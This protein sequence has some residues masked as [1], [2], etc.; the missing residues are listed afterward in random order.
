MV[1]KSWAKITEAPDFSTAS[2]LQQFRASNNQLSDISCL[3]G[4]ASINYIDV[5][6]NAEIK[7]IECLGACPMIVQINA[8]GTK[9]TKAKSLTDAGIVVHY[10][11]TG[12]SVE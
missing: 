11:P 8:F 7:D 5:D 1:R 3:A 12:S 4:L 6:Y 10:D 9:V 2:Y